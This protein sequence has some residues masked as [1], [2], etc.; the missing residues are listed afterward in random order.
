M[1]AAYAVPAH[2][3]VGTTV[4]DDRTGS[5]GHRTESTELFAIPASRLR[6]SPKDKADAPAVFRAAY[7][8]GAKGVQKTQRSDWLRFNSLGI[9]RPR[10]A[11]FLINNI[12]ALASAALGAVIAAAIAKVVITTTLIA[13]PV[14]WAVIIAVALTVLFIAGGEYVER[15]QTQQ[16]KKLFLSL[17]A[18]DFHDPERFREDLREH[19]LFLKKSYWKLQLNYVFYNK[20][21]FKYANRIKALQVELAK[22]PAGSQQKRALL[23]QLGKATAAYDFYRSKLAKTKENAVRDGDGIFATYMR[24]QFDVLVGGLE[25]KQDALRLQLAQRMKLAL[26][27]DDAAKR[28]FMGVVKS[29]LKVDD[30]AAEKIFTRAMVASRPEDGHRPLCSGVDAEVGMSL[31][32]MVRGVAEWPVEGVSAFFDHMREKMGI[33]G[34]SGISSRSRFRYGVGLLVLGG[35]ALGNGIAHLFAKEV[36]Q[37][38]LRALA[39]SVGRSG[40]EHM[41]ITGVGGAF[42]YSP[43]NLICSLASMA[44][45]TK[46]ISQKDEERKTKL[47]DIAAQVGLTAEDST[48]TIDLTKL[49]D[50]DRAFIMGGAGRYFRHQMQAF[51]ASIAEYRDLVK[52][53]EARLTVLDA[54]AKKTPEEKARVIA[55]LQVALTVCGDKMDRNL[56]E[57]QKYQRLVEAVSVDV[58]GSVREARR[59]FT[60]ASVVPPGVRYA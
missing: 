10:I 59:A 13:S 42:A 1:L 43:L 34:G 32:D 36:I 38:A 17:G 49:T 47:D 45:R 54:D 26:S 53:I 7:Q 4:R 31:S 22:A 41:M 40:L 19:S 52:K 35:I 50:A 27:D 12:G 25:G 23:I 58:D 46:M 20:M 24:E 16:A 11:A 57:I 37:G 39:D 56:R 28:V 8:A 21:T 30:N 6:K 9:S 5:S 60:P 33:Q 29:Q 51:Q 44:V 55:K 18:S 48:T 3:V 2:S 14:G 15:T